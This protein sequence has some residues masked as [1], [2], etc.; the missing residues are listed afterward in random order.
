MIIMKIAKC[1][2]LLQICTAFYFSN[3]IWLLFSSDKAEFFRVKK[4]RREDKRVNRIDNNTFA[5]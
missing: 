1:L 3:K 5:G 2:A 4:A